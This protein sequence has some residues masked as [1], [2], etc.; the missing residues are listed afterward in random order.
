MYNKI[1]IVILVIVS[2]VFLLTYVPNTLVKEGMKP[3]DNKSIEIIV[4]RY[5]EKLEWT[6]LYP[7]NKYKYTVYNKGPN[8][9]FNMSYVNKVIDLPNVGRESHTYLTH[10]INNYDNLSDINVFLPGSIDTTHKIFKKKLFAQKLLEYVNKY[11]NAIFLS[12]K[13]IKDNDITKEFKGFNVSAY[14]ST[15]IENQ[16][17]NNEHTI[18]KSLIRPYE[19]WFYT[20]F[21]NI[22]VPYV[23]HYG[24]FSV[25]KEDILQKPKSYYENLVKLVSDHSNPEDGHYFE[26][27][28]G[29]VFYPFKHTKILFNSNIVDPFKGKY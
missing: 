12:F 9:D 20:Q 8:N 21:G 7:F 16:K 6:N 14:R 27:S 2:V 25:S 24:I 29:A 11:N 4:S 5:N 17:I 1:L 13:N 23:I 19:K 10:I 3:N 28:W 22:K 18:R 15:T 26:K